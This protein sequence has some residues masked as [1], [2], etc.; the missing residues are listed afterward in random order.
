MAISGSAKMV[1]ITASKSFSVTLCSAKIILTHRH[2]NVYSFKP[3]QDVAIAR[4]R[5][6]AKAVQ[7]RSVGVAEEKV[8]TGAPSFS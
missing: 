3:Q 7:L 4:R 5:L 6:R 8:D 2:A 1:P